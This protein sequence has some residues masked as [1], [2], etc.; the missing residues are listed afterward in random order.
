MK[1]TL[2]ALALLMFAGG[3]LFVAA[4]AADTPPS[5]QESKAPINKFCAV[6]TKDEVDPAVTVE[7]NGKIV[8]FCCKDCIPTFKKDPEKYMKD[9]K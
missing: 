5:T 9:L 3:G 1:K 8:G 4:R 6:N 7:Y 2:L